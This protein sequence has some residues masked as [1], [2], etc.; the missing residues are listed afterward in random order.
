MEY[1]AIKLFAIEFQVLEKRKIIHF[2]IEKYINFDSAR[3]N[4]AS[5]FNAKKKTE[6]FQHH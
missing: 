6:I 3:S 4:N 2:E 1:S 5:A